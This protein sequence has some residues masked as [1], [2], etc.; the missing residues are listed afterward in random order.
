MIGNTPERWGTVS[1]AL[2]WTVAGLILC[3][4]LPT[5]FLMDPVGPGSLQN[6]LYFTHKNIGIVIFLLALFRL[7]WR[8]R[9]PVPAL[10]ADLSRWQVLAAHATHVLIYVVLFAMPVSGFLYTALGGF[11]IPF[12]GLYDLSRLLPTDKALSDIFLGIHEVGQWVL[13]VV[14]A[15]HVGG[16]LQHHFVRRD[17]VLRR[18]LSSKTPL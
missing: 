11:P 6:A 18:M 16:A 3:V 8:W 4:Q 15:M 1:I 2:H 17:H 12:L 13:Y 14:V 10:P 5:A 7:F 9:H